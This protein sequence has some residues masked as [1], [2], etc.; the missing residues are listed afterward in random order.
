VVDDD[1]KKAGQ[2]LHG[3]KIMG[4]TADIRRL[5]EKFAVDE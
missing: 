1:P 5:V 2:M 3:V 4:T